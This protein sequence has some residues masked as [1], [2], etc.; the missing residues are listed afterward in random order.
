MKRRLVHLICFFI[1][2][3]MMPLL[4]LKIFGEKLMDFMDWIVE[5]RWLFVKLVDFATWVEWELYE[6][7]GIDHRR[8][9]DFD[10]DED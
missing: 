9:P 7:W 8:H 1:L 2:L 5:G 3:P 6:R 10:D 4:L